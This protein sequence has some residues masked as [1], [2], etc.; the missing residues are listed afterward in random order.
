[1]SSIR[2]LRNER[3]LIVL[4]ATPSGLEALFDFLLLGGLLLGCFDLIRQLILRSGREVL[5][6][7]LQIVRR[8]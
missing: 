4:S 1:M 2:F 3:E 6:V 5:H 8:R 7:V